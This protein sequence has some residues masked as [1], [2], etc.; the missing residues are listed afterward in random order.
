MRR[1]TLSISYSPHRKC[2]LLCTQGQGTCRSPAWVQRIAIINETLERTMRKPSLRL[3]TCGP[4]SANNRAAW[5]AQKTQ[6]LQ[7]S[8]R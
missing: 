6:A 8:I 2:A 4:Q 3:Y 5:Q 7:F 1:S